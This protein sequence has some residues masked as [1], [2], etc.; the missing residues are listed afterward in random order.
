MHDQARTR[1]ITHERTITHDHARS[2][3]ITHDQARTLTITLLLTFI[4][5]NPDRLAKSSELMRAKQYWTGPWSARG[6]GPTAKC[7]SFCTTRIAAIERWEERIFFHIFSHASTPGPRTSTHDHARARRHARMH[8]HFLHLRVHLL[9]D[10]H[11]RLGCTFM[12]A[13]THLARM[14]VRRFQHSGLASRW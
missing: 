1:T 10:S 3:T 9:W 8:A 11:S 5:E 13:R 2:R 7:F 14:V 6:I 12:H 4:A